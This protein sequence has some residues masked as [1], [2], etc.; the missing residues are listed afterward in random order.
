M[1][2]KGNDKVSLLSNKEIYKT[3]KILSQNEQNLSVDQEF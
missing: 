1:K 2:M 3:Q